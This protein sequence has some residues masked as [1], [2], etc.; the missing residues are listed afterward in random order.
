MLNAVLSAQKTEDG[1][2][3]WSSMQSLDLTLEQALLVATTN[4]YYN[5]YL[6]ATLR[7]AM[8]ENEDLTQE[9]IPQETEEE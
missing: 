4:E 8:L 5:P 1:Y 2:K 7:Q 6:R 3:V 9:Q